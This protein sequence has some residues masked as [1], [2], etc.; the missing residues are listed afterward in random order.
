M[1][2]TLTISRARTASQSRQWPSIIAPQDCVCV[3]TVL[4]GDVR[5]RQ[6]LC[7]RKR[8]RV[9]A[10]RPPDFPRYT[11]QEGGLFVSL[12]RD[13]MLARVEAE[14]VAVGRIAGGV[15]PGEVDGGQGTLGGGGAVELGPAG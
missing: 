4:N 9:R 5:V 15:F 1:D 3:S 14:A 8:V 10:L 13:R 7:F 6:A 12:V 11:P 2:A